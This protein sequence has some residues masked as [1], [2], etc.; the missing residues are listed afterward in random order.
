LKRKKGRGVA[1]SEP[2]VKE[3]F[4]E[5]T[6]EE[7]FPYLT[8]SEKYVLWMG[9]TAEIEARPGGIFKLDP[10]TLDVIHGEFLEVSPPKRVVFT[11]G[12]K[13]P[14]HPVPAG[15]TRVEIDLIAQD[16]GTIL[17]LT[18]FHVPDVIRQRHEFGWTHYL[19]RLKIVMAGGD[20]GADPYSDPQFRH[21]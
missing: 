17:R 4:I 7:I 12:W 9:L 2:I 18:H 21:R 6:P 3:I 13:E 8:R 16:G 5:A 14:G 10:N 11:W 20:P 19:G 15:S 1:A